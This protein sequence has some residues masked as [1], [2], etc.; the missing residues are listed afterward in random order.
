MKKRFKNRFRNSCFLVITFF[1]I[2]CS[3]ENQDNYS[4]NAR[5]TIFEMFGTAMGGK[6]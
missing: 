2:A 5:A 4:E 3:V 6:K 1:T